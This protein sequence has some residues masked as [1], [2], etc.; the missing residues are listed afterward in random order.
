MK[1]RVLVWIAAAFSLMSVRPM[2]A[3]DK[4]EVAAR[5]HSAEV[6]TSLD[7]EDLK[8]WYLKLD[9][10]LYDEKGTPTESGT[11]EER[12]ARPH[13]RLVVYSLPS[14]TSK[15]LENSDGVFRSGEAGAAPMVIQALLDQVVHPMPPEYE[16]NQS[17]P[18][19]RKH[20]FGKVPLDCIMLSQPIK[21]VSVVP[22][23]LFPTYCFDPGKDALRLSYDFGTQVVIRN[24]TGIFQ[25][26]SVP[27]DVRVNSGQFEAATGRIESLRGMTVDPAQFTKT[28][29]MKKVGNLVRIGG[30]VMAGTIISKSQPI[31]PESARR[32]H[33]SGSVVLRAIIGKDGHVHVLQLKSAPDPDLAI[34][35]IAAVRQW[36]Y[37]PYFLNGEATEVDT[38]ITV[39]FNIGP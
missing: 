16:I 23:G 19:L 14:Y 37:K 31:Y 29:D 3:V 27:M 24:R 15:V 13:Q 39:N 11:I 10:Q 12:W 32:N 22:L 36:V 34:A 1:T 18:E 6:E 35:A 21:T 25:G 33:V 5:L 28:D 8:P 26:H 7:T 2:F 17:Q 30:G 4:A 20:N 9:V 38:T